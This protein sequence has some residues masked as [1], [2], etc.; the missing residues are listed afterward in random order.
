ML[1]FY[2]FVGKLQNFLD[3]VAVR[4]HLSLLAF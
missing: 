3:S 1:T 4:I 2:A